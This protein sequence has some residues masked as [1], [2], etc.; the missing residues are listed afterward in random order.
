MGF[1]SLAFR[2]IAVDRIL[3]LKEVSEGQGW[4]VVHLLSSRCACSKRA[5]KYLSERGAS[6]GLF[7]T[8]LILDGDLK[9]ES[10][11]LAK[12]FKVVKMSGDNA[13]EK[14]GIESVPQFVVV[15]PQKNIRYSGGYNDDRVDRYQDLT[16]VDSIKENIKVAALPIFG[17]ANGSRISNLI[18]P[19]GLKYGVER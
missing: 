5:S 10:E 12:G 7:E 6:A 4:Q 19:W 9:R 2:N 14:Y 8:V 3:G 17:C 16:I 15:D 18:D 13:F 11:L 1:H